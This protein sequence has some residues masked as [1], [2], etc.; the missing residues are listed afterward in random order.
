MRYNALDGHDV[1]T[2]IEKHHQSQPDFISKAGTGAIITASV[3][4][5]VYQSDFMP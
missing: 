1:Y 3:I 2:A 5:L 4:D